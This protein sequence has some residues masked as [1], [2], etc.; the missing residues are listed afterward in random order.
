MYEIKINV[1][2]SGVYMV[3]FESASMGVKFRDL[4]YLMLQA[5]DP[6]DA[7]GN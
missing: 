2:E 3:F 5:V 4:P 7:G 1:P 6:K